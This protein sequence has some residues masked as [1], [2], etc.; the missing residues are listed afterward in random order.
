M[1]WSTN[2]GFDIGDEGLYMLSLTDPDRYS[3]LAHGHFFNSILPIEHFTI[4]ISRM[5]SIAMEL[6]GG[7]LF[8]LGL[9]QW[10]KKHVEHTI[11]L[12][13]VW[14][15]VLV[16][17][18]H[19]LFARCVSYNDIIY[20][21]GLSA[22]G[23]LLLSFSIKKTWQRL[24]LWSISFTLVTFS[25]IFKT[26]VALS[27]S[28]LL[29]VVIT[30]E[31]SYERLKSLGLGLT[32]MLTGGAITIGLYS[33]LYN[34]T[35]W[36]DVIVDVKQTAD[37]LNY[38]PSDLIL[39]YLIYDGVPNI[40]FIGIGAAVFS[41]MWYMLRTN[42]QLSDLM[43][44]V[45]S[46]IVTIAIGI[47]AIVQLNVLLIPE[48]RIAY[49]YL[50]ILLG[51]L[52]MLLYHLIKLKS[53]LKQGTWPVLFFL[54]ALP[55][56]LIGGTNGFITETL[57]TF[58]MPWFGLV[59]IGIHLLKGQGLSFIKHP[60]IPSLLGVSML[61]LFV[62]TKVFHPFGL[63]ENEDLLSQT[64][65]LSGNDGLLLDE[66]S[67]Q[68]ITS[69]QRSVSKH[70]ND[71]QPAILAMNYTPGLVYL[72][73]GYSPGAPFFMFHP[74]FDQ[75]NCQ[76]IAQA[77]AE[78]NRPIIVYRNSIQDKAEACL[79]NADWDYPETYTVEAILDPYST[80]HEG[81]EATNGKL[82]LAFPQ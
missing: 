43:A 76:N 15:F 29:L 3:V 24:V 52:S 6:A 71:D 46:S 81:A 27:L 36:V 49:P 7:L 63:P 68:Y 50:W 69:I 30:L 79:L 10:L 58:W 22:A 18:F 45:I 77:S 55:I 73:S 28:L 26:P 35:G 11:S 2:R 64:T 47:V 74:D 54:F 34:G 82:Y 37:L 62:H 65:L 16:G 44:F 57:L 78:V 42:T 48:E 19:S 23:T 53:T 75:Y 72:T 21:L 14:A 70:S 51:I 4:P 20:F 12:F 61:L 33:L 31:G 60:I 59:L 40:I 8:S 5:I 13:T 41:S 66:K 17:T 9:H 25:A 1:L 67:H 56:G 38:R 39:M 32:S 80:V